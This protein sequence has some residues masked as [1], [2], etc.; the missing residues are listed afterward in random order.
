MRDLTRRLVSEWDRNAAF[1]AASVPF[2]RSLRVREKGALTT[3]DALIGFVASFSNSS[4]PSQLLSSLIL[5]AIARKKTQFLQKLLIPLT[6]L[7]DLPNEVQSALLHYALHEDQEDFLLAIITQRDIHLYIESLDNYD[8]FS[9]YSLSF[10]KA[11]LLLPLLSFDTELERDAFMLREFN[12]ALQR[13]NWKVAEHLEE[14]NYHTSQTKIRELQGT[15]LAYLRALK[16]RDEETLYFLSKIVPPNTL[17]SNGSTIFIETVRKR[18]LNAARNFLKKGADPNATSVGTQ[19]PLMLSAAQNNVA[20]M[21]ILI[22]HGAEIDKKTYCHETALFFATKN[23]QNEA[24]ELLKKRGANFEGRNLSGE[25]P[26]F[27][28]VKNRS[29]N[30]VKT[31][32]EC[33]ADMETQDAS[34]DTPICYAIFENNEEIAK[35]FIHQGANLGSFKPDGMTPLHFTALS[36]SLKIAKALIEKGADVNAKDSSGNTPLHL[37]SKRKKRELISLLL[38]NKADVQAK[39]KDGNSALNISIQ[40]GDS[41]SVEL[42]IL[43]GANC[44]SRNARTQTPL[45]SCYTVPNPER[46]ELIKPFLKAF[47]IRQTSAEKVAE[48]IIRGNFQECHPNDLYI[49]LTLYGRANLADTWLKTKASPEARNVTLKKLSL[50]ETNAH[51]QRAYLAV[52]FEI[53]FELLK[54]TS[55]QLKTKRRDDLHPLEEGKYPLSKLDNWADVSQ[56]SSIKKIL[57]HIR[58][59]TRITATPED[60]DERKVWYQNLTHILRHVIKRLEDR[61]NEDLQKNIILILSEASGW[62]GRRYRQAAEMCLAMVT[63]KPQALSPSDKIDQITL[64]YRNALIQRLVDHFVIYLG[65]SNLVD[66]AGENSMVEHVRARVQQALSDMGINPDPLSD[67][68]YV[69]EETLPTDLIKNEFLVLYSPA[70]IAA[71]IAMAIQNREIDPGLILDFLKDNVT[72]KADDFREIET[73]LYT[74][75]H[76]VAPIDRVFLMHELHKRGVIQIINALGLSEEGEAFNIQEVMPCIRRWKM[77]EALK[78]YDLTLIAEFLATLPSLK[79]A[80]TLSRTL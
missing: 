3:E 55:R 79:D 27:V 5:D 66:E 63:N 26:L 19:T 1:V 15:L 60:P 16:Y 48:V 18:F 24:I 56:R 9:I 47:L 44:L 35:L 65:Y 64:D 67:D 14:T 33:G 61:P 77:D 22:D 38:Q 42:L 13:R 32:L 68:E 30:A 58:N 78:E 34:N 50:L 70:E 36:G 73:L 23:G 4:P 25:T 71:R 45:F 2:R 31:L 62:C 10:A 46:V 7:K 43:A 28:A 57:D 69:S 72:W 20:M 21:N 53:N 54:E 76:T 29:V 8:S 40:M 80:S 37:A 75:N 51:Y 52:N 12:K 41:E 17:L 6:S 39:N 11:R 74:Y 59:N 49:L